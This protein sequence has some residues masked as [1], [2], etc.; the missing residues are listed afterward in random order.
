MVELYRK[1]AAVVVCNSQGKVLSCQRRDSADKEKSWQ[2]PQGGVEEGESP[3]AAALRELKE[4]TGLTQVTLLAE[5]PQP[6]RYK[7]SAN[8]IEKFKKLGRQNV[9][10]EQYWFLFLY[11]G[12]DDAINFETNPQEIEFI[13]FDWIDIMQAPDKVIEFKHEVYE[14][15]CA[16]FKP[17]VEQQKKQSS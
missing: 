2:F 15:I 10:Q 11:T 5:Y 17:F 8:V 9:G 1:N 12:S 13:A 7:F 6:L 4:E 16:Y 3:I 14:K